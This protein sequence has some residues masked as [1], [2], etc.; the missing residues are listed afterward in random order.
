MNRSNISN[1][2]NRRLSLSLGGTNETSSEKNHPTTN[3]QTI[4]FRILEVSSEDPNHPVA[5]LESTSNNTN[6]NVSSR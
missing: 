4:P 2:S 1:S 6:N 5:S 3:N